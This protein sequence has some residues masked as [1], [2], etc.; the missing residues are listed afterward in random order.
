MKIVGIGPARIVLAG[1]R[2]D[3]CC[4]SR[5]PLLTA[6][7]AEQR[8]VTRFGKPGG[9]SV[10]VDLQPGHAQTCDPVSFDGTPPSEEFFY[11]Q[12]V[13]AANFFESDGAAAHCI[14]D[15]RLAPGDPAFRV[16]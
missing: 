10:A 3:R 14:D 9:G 6:G 11:R 4:A 2:R 1:D 13:A 5:E 16:G 8:S 15:H 12:L 7:A